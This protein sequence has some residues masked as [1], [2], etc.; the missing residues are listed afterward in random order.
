[1]IQLRFYTTGMINDR[2]LYSTLAF[3]GVLPFLA[4]ALLPLAGVSQVEPFGRLDQV[5]NS[6]GL[7]IVC[8]LAGI[9]WATSLLSPDRT[10]FNLFIVSNVVFLVT[11][12]AF[13]LA[14]TKWSLITECAALIVLL[15]IDRKLANSEVIS[16]SYLQA[17]IVATV[18]ASAALILIAL[19]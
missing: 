11:W 15:L 7:A 2:V 18:L 17:R 1:M 5:A 16:R 19:N 14:E 10:P 9:H 12:F 3:A 4:C 13:V 8:F 6:Y